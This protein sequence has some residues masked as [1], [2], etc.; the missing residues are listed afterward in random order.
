[1]DKPK[2]HFTLTKKLPKIKIGKYYAGLKNGTFGATN[3]WKQ[4]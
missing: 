1:M 4:E 3:N 2:P